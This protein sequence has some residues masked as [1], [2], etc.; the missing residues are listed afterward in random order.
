MLVVEVFVCYIDG[1]V[2]MD[3]EMVI[4]IVNDVFV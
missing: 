2:L 3:V 1:V 4:F